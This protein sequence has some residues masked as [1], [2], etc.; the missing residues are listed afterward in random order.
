MLR[1]AGV[2]FG[3]QPAK[4]DEDAIK[5]SMLSEGASA[6]DIADALA[7][8]KSSKVSRKNPGAFVI[9]SDQVLEHTGDLLTKPTDTA[10]AIQQLMQLRGQ[11]HTLYSAVV[12]SENGHPVW[13]HIGKVSLRMREFSEQYA[14]AYVERNWSRIRYSVGSYNYEEEGIRLFASVEGDYF[15][16]LGMPLLPTL[17][18]L[19]LRGALES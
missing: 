13:R 7:E 12:I 19:T 11:A 5:S 2:D 15:T 3:L 9:G 8:A 6:R 18:Y 17:N 10:A 4:I 16:V 1:A 14:I